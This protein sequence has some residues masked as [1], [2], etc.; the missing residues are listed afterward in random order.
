MNSRDQ[1]LRRCYAAALLAGHPWPEYAACEAA[2]ESAWG[3]SRLAVEANNLFGEKQHQQPI[4]ETLDMMTHEVINGVSEFVPAHWVKF[5]DWASCFNSRI[6]TIR[7]LADEYAH[8]G[9][10]AALQATNG[11]DFVREVSKNWST[12]PLRADK[13]IQIHNAH[14]QAFV[15]DQAPATSS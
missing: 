3:T 12:D 5:P 10:M 14:A 15:P 2:L 1:F 13:V 9:Y 11:E 4:Y 7:R 6:A 8:P